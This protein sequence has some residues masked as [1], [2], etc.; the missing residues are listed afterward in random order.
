MVVES[1]EDD[2]V[3]VDPEE[4]GVVDDVVVELP[5]EVVVIVEPSEVDVAVEP[6]KAVVYVEEDDVDAVNVD[7]ETSKLTEE[8]VSVVFPD[9]TWAMI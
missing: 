2:V 7:G 9:V 5:E 6:D 1:P 8:V 4:L 3:V